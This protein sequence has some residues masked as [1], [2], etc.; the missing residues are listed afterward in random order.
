VA[1]MGV[2][3]RSLDGERPFPGASHRER[4]DPL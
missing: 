4:G 2:V 3:E 1:H